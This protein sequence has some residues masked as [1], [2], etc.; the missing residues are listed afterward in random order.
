MI[1]NKE[2]KIVKSEK[3]VYMPA[4]NGHYVLDS[5]EKPRFYKSVEALEKNTKAG[6]YD[7]ILVYSLKE[8]RKV[9]FEEDVIAKAEQE[10]QE[11]KDFEKAKNA[12]LRAKKKASKKPKK[13]DKKK[14]SKKTSKAK[15]KTK[16]KKEEVKEAVIETVIE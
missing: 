6:Y 3:K 11:K 1:I 12:E 13:T 4:K 2:K 15:S 5:R 10:I 7:T 16:A 8:E 9:L 14:T